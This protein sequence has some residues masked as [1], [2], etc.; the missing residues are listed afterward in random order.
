MNIIMKQQKQ[1]RE[2]AAESVAKSKEE[3]LIK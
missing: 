3:L 2:M 1:L